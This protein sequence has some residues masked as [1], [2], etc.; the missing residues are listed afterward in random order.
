MCILQSDK[1]ENHLA[2]RILS[3]LSFYFLKKGHT[4]AR[5]TV[6]ADSAPSTEN[7]KAIFSLVKGN[8]ASWAVAVVC[9]KGRLRCCISRALA[10]G[11]GR[12]LNFLRKNEAFP[13]R[14]NKGEGDLS[15]SPSSFSEI[16]QRHRML[17][18]APG[19]GEE[20]KAG[21]P[22]A[23]ASRSEWEFDI[24]FNLRGGF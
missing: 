23:G 13:G 18:T 19:S 3:T 12:R 9:G 4:R 1:W 15:R 7:G 6:I 10:P 24:S 17:S 20:H 11:N 21:D 16:V 2:N 14:P 5:A 8:V 22:Q